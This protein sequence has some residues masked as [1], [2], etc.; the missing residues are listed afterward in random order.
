MEGQKSS[1]K[2]HSTKGNISTINHSPSESEVLEET[3]EHSVNPCDGSKPKLKSA[4]CDCNE[5][6]KVNQNLT[7]QLLT[8]S[9]ESIVLDEI[10]EKLNYKF[11]S[12]NFLV[13]S[14]CKILER[15][16]LNFSKCCNACKEL[17]KLTD[18]KSHKLTVFFGHLVLKQAITKY[19][20][21]TYPDLQSGTLTTLRSN[22]MSNVKLARVAIVK[23]QVHKHMSF[24]DK[25]LEDK[26][27][28][29]I[30]DTNDNCED[31]SPPLFFCN[32]VKS[33]AGAMF[34]DNSGVML[35]SNSYAIDKVWEKFKIL[36]EPLAT[37]ETFEKHPATE[38]DGLLGKSAHRVE[39]KDYNFKICE[40]EMIAVEVFIDDQMVGRGENK[41]KKMAKRIAARRALEYLKLKSSQKI[42]SEKGLVS[43]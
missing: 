33:I 30:E 18:L 7:C 15:V 37:V 17:I 40:E 26:V 28:R 14:Y 2:E 35:E 1:C 23:L 9:Y 16:T 4:K 11:K 31:V 36:L 6:T 41:K 25:S 32:I 5:V 24:Q 43:G 13:D 34:L 42:S 19:L 22:I 3:L 27:V 10:E 8:P 20:Y 39:Y 38:L 29:L 12:R 21:I